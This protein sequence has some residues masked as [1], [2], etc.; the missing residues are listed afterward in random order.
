[1]ARHE[2]IVKAMMPKENPMR[3]E[4]VGL[5]YAIDFLK[6]RTSTQFKVRAPTVR[7]NAN[8]DKMISRSDLFLSEQRVNTAHAVAKAVKVNASVK[9]RLVS[10]KAGTVSRFQ[11]RMRV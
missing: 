3:R 5:R 10:E 8:A 6:V 11:Q 4:T 1:M 7:V 2:R 9:I